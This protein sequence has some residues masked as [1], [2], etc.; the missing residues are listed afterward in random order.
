MAEDEGG[1]DKVGHSD[2]SYR[3]TAWINVPFNQVAFKLAR[4]SN[5]RLFNASIGVAQIS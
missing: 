5:S 2:Q 1:D 4:S 3:V